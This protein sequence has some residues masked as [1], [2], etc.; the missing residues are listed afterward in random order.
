MVLYAL[1]NLRMGTETTHWVLEYCY[2]CKDMTSLCDEIPY[3]HLLEDLNVNSAWEII[4]I[5]E[6]QLKRV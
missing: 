4:A 3:S 2:Q 5:S 6:F 1:F